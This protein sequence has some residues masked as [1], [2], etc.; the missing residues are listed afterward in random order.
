MNWNWN[1]GIPIGVCI[2]AICGVVGGLFVHALQGGCDC[3]WQGVPIGLFSVL[4]PALG[5]YFAKK[6]IGVGS[7]I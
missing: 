5:V 3:F 1:M 4:I 6:Q 2:T 7:P